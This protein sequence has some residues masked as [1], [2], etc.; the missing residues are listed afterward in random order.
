M[1]AVLRPGG[2]L[3]IWEPTVP[4]PGP[5]ARKTFVVPVRAELPERTIRTLFGVR[6]E[7]HEMSSDT[8]AQAAQEVGFTLVGAEQAGASFFLTLVRSSL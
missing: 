4:T 7:G 3:R 5:K 1:A 2:T 8:I 6:W